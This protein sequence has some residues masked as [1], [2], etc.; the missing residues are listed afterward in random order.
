MMYTYNNAYAFFL[1]SFFSS[2]LYID[3]TVTLVSSRLKINTNF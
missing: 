2:F 3:L 1:F